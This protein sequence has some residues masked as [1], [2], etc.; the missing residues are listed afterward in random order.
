VS[1]LPS[2][3]APYIVDETWVWIIMIAFFSPWTDVN[4][5]VLLFNMSC[6]D[7]NLNNSFL[8]S[9]FLPNSKRY[10]TWL[11]ILSRRTIYLMMMNSRRSR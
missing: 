1:S 8:L 9:L 11:M 7:L 3:G 10:L 4:I 2:F 5:V 6:R